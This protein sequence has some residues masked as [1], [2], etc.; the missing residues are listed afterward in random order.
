MDW[1]SLLQRSGVQMLVSACFS[2]LDSLRVALSH[3]QGNGT[4]PPYLSVCSSLSP[5]LPPSLPHLFPSLSHLPPSLS[6]LP[7]IHSH[8]R[9]FL[10]TK[11]S[12]MSGP[13]ILINLMHT[14]GSGSPLL[15]FSFSAMH[16]KLEGSLLRKLSPS[17]PTHQLFPLITSQLVI[18]ELSPLEVFNKNPNSC[19]KTKGM[20]K[21]GSGDTG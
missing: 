21:D 12:I 7:P 2:C 17:A 15:A 11:K 9:S 8:P 19:G 5:S 6:H 10:D 1:A 16:S 3:C 18:M 20:G 4:P 13:Q 14:S